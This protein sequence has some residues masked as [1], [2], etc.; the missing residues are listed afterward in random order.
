[1]G[2]SKKRGCAW[3]C[4]TIVALIV[5]VVVVGVLLVVFVW[6]PSQRRSYTIDDVRIQATVRPN[7]T[8]AATE[9]FSY[10]FEGDYTRVY[11]DLPFRPFEPVTVV[12][13]TGPDGPLK[14]LPS[15]WTPAAGPPAPVSP[16]DDLTPSPWSSLAPEQR[17]PGY[18]RVTY[19]YGSPIGPAVRIEAFADLSDRSATFTYRWLAAGAAERFADT[20]E[21]SWQLVGRGWD[22]PM[23]RVRAVVSLPAGASARRVRAG[24]T[25]R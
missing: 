12:A 9:R 19:D 22:V 11:R 7:G 8:L 5:A 14:R 1:M 21:L 6:I 23:K 16:R 24:G 10:T 20:G 17:P 15:G 3:G 4:G 25:A 2:E 18:Y 13:V